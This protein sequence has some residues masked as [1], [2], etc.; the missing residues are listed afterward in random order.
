MRDPKAANKPQVVWQTASY[1][2]R[3]GLAKGL[4]EQLIDKLRE[5]FYSF[6]IDKATSLN[7]HKWLTLLVS[8]FC[9]TKN[10]VVFEHLGS[11]NLPT[12]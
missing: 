4:E 1:K 11:L 8:Y 10:E 3:H 6:N 5:G 9:T 2:T 7:L 12:I